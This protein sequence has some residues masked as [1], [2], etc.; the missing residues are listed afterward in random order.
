MKKAKKQKIHVKAGDIIKII[1]GKY[2]GQIGEIQKIFI[3]TG[4]VLIN[5][6]NIKTKHI[7]P[8][9]EGETGQIIKIEAAIHSSNVMIYSKEKQIASRCKIMIND[10]QI[11]QK[12]LKKT[13]EIV[14]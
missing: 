11:K 2:K 9:Q 5:N 3:K 10:Q 14:K 12:I 8:K 4:K 1:S 6:I 13:G 7:R